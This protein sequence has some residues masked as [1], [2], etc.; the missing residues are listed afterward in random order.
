[1]F[2]NKNRLTVVNFVVIPG[3]WLLYLQIKVHFKFKDCVIMVKNDPC[4]LIILGLEDSSIEISL[5]KT[6]VEYQGM[7]VL[8]PLPPGFG[9]L[10]YTSSVSSTGCL[11]PD[12]TNVFGD[13]SWWN[14]Y[15]NMS[16]I[17]YTFLSMRYIFFYVLDI[18]IWTW[19]CVN[20]KFSHYLDSVL[21]YY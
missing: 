15:T 1:M 14:Q 2:Q 7:Y 10:A 16:A 18:N 17:K 5:P 11:K 13:I 8:T 9:L 12:V 4:M 3:Q 21:Y 6:R 19:R 20:Y